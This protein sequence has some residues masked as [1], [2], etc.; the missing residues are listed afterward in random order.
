MPFEDK[1]TWFQDDPITPSMP[2]WIALN[3]EC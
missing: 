3:S 1:E 2:F